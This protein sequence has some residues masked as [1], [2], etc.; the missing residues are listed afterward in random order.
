MSTSVL[1]KTKRDYSRSCGG[2]SEW[3]DWDLPRL[4]LALK[5]WRDINS[6]GEESNNVPKGKSCSYHAKERKS[7]ARVYCESGDHVSSTCT[8]VTTLKEGKHFWRKRECAPIALELSIT[9]PIAGVGQDVRNVV[10]ST[11]HT[12]VPRK[13]NS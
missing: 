6:V 2:E 10:N 12:S 5:K 4:V 7:R 13:I 1:K 8:C 3:Q 9:P 11:I